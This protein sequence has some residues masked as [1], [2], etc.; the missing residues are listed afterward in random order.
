MSITWDEFADYLNEVQSN[1]KRIPMRD[2]IFL[3][4]M[5]WYG[6]GSG[7]TVKKVMN[8]W[9]RTGNFAPSEETLASW[10]E[11]SNNL[12][13]SGAFANVEWTQEWN[14]KAWEEG[15]LVNRKVLFYFANANQYKNISE[16][17]GRHARDQKSSGRGTM[18]SMEICLLLLRLLFL[19]PPR[20][21]GF[22]GGIY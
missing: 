22:S 9:I 14:S 7:R 20:I 19:K 5:T 1:W 12:R 10:Y 2:L 21:R 8:G 15:P 17:Y 6:C 16:F 18:V 4:T 13:K 3:R 11:Y